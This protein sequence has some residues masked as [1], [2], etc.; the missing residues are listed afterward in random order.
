MLPSQTLETRL[1]SSADPDANQLV[2][3]I[4]IQHAL[5]LLRGVLVQPNPD[6]L[7][8]SEE[9]S[10]FR[11]RL[12]DILQTEQAELSAAA[13]LWRP[14]GLP[15]PERAQ[16]LVRGLMGG[17]ERFQPERPEEAAERMNQWT[18]DATRG[19][20][21]RIA[22][23]EMIHPELELALLSALYLKAQWEKPF[24]RVEEDAPLW[25]LP[26]GD[27]VETPM[28]RSPLK[29]KGFF[30]RDGVTGVRVPYRGYELFFELLLPEREEQ[31]AGLLAELPTL[32]PSWR[33]V[34]V[35][36][37]MPLFAFSTSYS[38]L[39]PLADAFAP[40]TELS[41]QPPSPVRL[42][43][44]THLCRIEVDEQGTEASAVT[45]MFAAA[46]S[47]PPPPQTVIA[48]RPFCFRISNQHGQVLFSGQLTDP[49]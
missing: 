22:T 16:E 24:Q 13:S 10:L 5:Q 18:S 15:L 29:S 36:L 1:L 46:C 49:R 37:T 39:A 11:A 40:P 31:R 25:R 32:Q 21:K 41:T 12:Q 20:I 23:P 43:S 14:L 44:A 6:L 48:D 26:G 4:N 27:K 33:Q 35:R 9:P 8:L 38:L 47:L 17:V 34:P 7:S 30:Q 45:G 3:G 42:E 19:M 28:M 2:S